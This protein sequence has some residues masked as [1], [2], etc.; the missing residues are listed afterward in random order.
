MRIYNVENALTSLVKNSKSPITKYHR[1]LSPQK[2]GKEWTLSSV[3]LGNGDLCT[4]CRLITWMQRVRGAHRSDSVPLPES[5]LKGITGQLQ[6]HTW[7]AFNSALLTKWYQEGEPPFLR[8]PVSV[9]KWSPPVTSVPSHS[10]LKAKE[11]THWVA[12]SDCLCFRICLPAL[13]ALWAA[14]CDSF[15]G[16]TALDREGLNPACACGD[17][18]L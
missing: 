15:Y 7:R 9:G 18:T 10:V 2:S 8:H 4:A 13:W 6:K 16:N 12:R 17:G 11:V 1:T 14:C 3:A 5:W